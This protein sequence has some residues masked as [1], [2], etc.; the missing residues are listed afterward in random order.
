MA[1]TRPRLPRRSP[2][3]LS[4]EERKS[5]Q[6]RMLLPQLEH[7]YTNSLFYRRSFDAAGIRPDDIK[8]LEDYYERVPF[9][10]KE[11]FIDDQ[12]KTPPFGDLLSLPARQIRHVFYAPGPLLVP[13]SEGDLRWVAQVAAR[14]LYV[15]GLRP[16]MLVDVT[17]NY[18]WVIAG[19]ALDQAL[20]TGGASVLCGGVGNSRTH[21]ELLKLTRASAFMAFPSY[22]ETLAETA[23]SMGVD[24]RRELNVR[25]IFIFGEV[26]TEKAKRELGETFGASVRDMY[27]TADLGI[28]AGECSEGGGMHITGD[29][30]LEVIDPATGKQVPWGDGGEVVGC[31]LNRYGLPVIRYRT[32][33]I[34]EGVNLEPC[35]CGLRTPRLKRILGRLGDIARIKGMF[36][37]P[38]QVE[39]VISCYPELGRY[40]IQVTRPGLRDELKICVECREPAPADGMRARIIEQLKSALRVTPDVELVKLGTIPEGAG[41]VRDLRTV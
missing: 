26:R 24:P 38:R 28:V 7:A 6:W 20:R 14:V 17:L 41:V 23:K 30:I 25:T 31:N 12:A 10:S 18:N 19:K 27:G 15:M 11:A 8:S 33:D 40:Q 2:E 39:S 29:N 36:I 35:S 16:G 22:A 5:L 34:A 21:I 37:S 3:T 9:S 1:A 4:E 32:G 13:M